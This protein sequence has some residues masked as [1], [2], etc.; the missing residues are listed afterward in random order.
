MIVLLRAALRLFAHLA[1]VL[2]NSER[3]K[4]PTDHRLATTKVAELL[5][6]SRGSSCARSARS[7]Q[8]RKGRRALRRD[9]TRVNLGLAIGD[10]P[11]YL[12]ISRQSA[13]LTRHVIRSG[14]SV[15]KWTDAPRHI[16]EHVGTLWVSCGRHLHVASGPDQARSQVNYYHGP[17]HGC[18]PRLRTSDQKCPKARTDSGS[19]ATQLVGDREWD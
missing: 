2:S 13:C 8:M 16:P 9:I 15:Q 5:R 7:A 3:S 11:T 14:T 1:C 17:N 12:A 10:I 18:G 4:G 6:R 19:D